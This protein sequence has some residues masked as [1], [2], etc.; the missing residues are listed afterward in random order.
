MLSRNLA[1]FITQK[2]DAIS[3][4][5]R[6]FKFRVLGVRLKGDVH[7]RRILIPR[8]FHDIEI[9]K[10]TYIDDG[11][12]IIISGEPTGNPK[13]RIGENCGFNRYTII[14]ASEWVEFKDCARIGPGCYITDH[15]H[16]TKANALIMNQGLTSSP[17]IIGRDVWLGA[18]VS[19]LKGVTIGDGA[20]IGAGSVV[21][22][23]IPAQSIAVGTPAKVIA[24]RSASTPNHKVKFS[25]I[26]PFYN[27]EDYVDEVLDS[28]AAQSETDYEIIAV[29]DG[30]VDKT[31][32][33]L[34]SHPAN[35]KCIRI[36]NSGAPRARNAAIAQAQGE[37]LAFLDSDDLWFP[38]TLSTYRKVIDSHN[39]P[40]VLVGTPVVFS[41]DDITLESISPATEVEVFQNYLESFEEWR[42]RGVSSFVVKSEVCR[43]VGCFVDKNINAED[44]D[45]MLRLGVA[46]GFVHIRE[47]HTFAYRVHDSNLTNNHSKSL[48]GLKYIVNQE[49]QNLYPGSALHQRLKR[50]III[51]RHLRPL[52]LALLRD[53]RTKEA[54]EL[55]RPAIPW[56][57][58]KL[59][60]RFLLY[61]GF[62]ILGGLFRSN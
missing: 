36:E 61:S 45:L 40:A 24:T 23:D 18:N 47:P 5:I 53:G 56:H 57:L 34:Q 19:V 14:D 59:R 20:V 49:K 13:V 11:T 55:Y 62:K 6:Y 2:L 22:K 54:M 31:W 25:I 42:W 46:G 9:N 35:P 3:R 33:K 58:R 16:K 48:A 51:T 44:A 32:E 41:D 21:T 30:S 39:N 29:D 12:V 26:I 10:G 52:I 15:N 7:L 43:E 38:N 37:Y 27:R 17:T 1:N 4:R 28:V 8:N 50:R 60:F